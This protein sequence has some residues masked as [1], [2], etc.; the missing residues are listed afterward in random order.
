MVRINKVYTKTGDSGMTFLAG[1]QKVSKTSPRI[2]A[3][4]SVDELNSSIGIIVEFLK[5]IPELT[6]LKEQILRIQNE[7]FDL[8]SQ[9]AV[10]KED[11]RPDTPLIDE[12]NIHILEREID[13]MNKNLPSLSSFILPGGGQISAFLHL[14][15]TICRRVER[16]VIHLSKT[17]GI[18]GPELPYLNRLSDWLFV[19]ARYSTKICGD[20]ETLWRPGQRNR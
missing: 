13:E 6:K 2:V 16:E 20:D 3:Y 15:R 8:G 4:G 10:L 7:L 9:L 14:A 5:N 1:G 19:A 12:E 18:D 11:R 17:E